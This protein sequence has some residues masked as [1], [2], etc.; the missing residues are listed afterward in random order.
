VTIK[1]A[2][3]TKALAM[4]LREA[5]KLCRE[6]FEQYARQY[7]GRTLAIKLIDVGDDVGFALKNGI[8]VMLNK[9]DNPTVVMKCSM[10]VFRATLAGKVHEDDLFYA[11]LAEFEGQQVLRDKIIL[12]RMVQS[13][14]KVGLIG[15]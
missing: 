2:I 13:F 7:P 8:L 11:G 10:R 12:S 1:D 9:V 14:R 5:N 6:D 15:A 4:K 3:I